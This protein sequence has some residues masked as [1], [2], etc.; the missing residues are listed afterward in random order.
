MTQRC[1]ESIGI[2]LFSSPGGMR[3]T[4]KA[5]SKRPFGD[6]DNFVSRRFNSYEIVWKEPGS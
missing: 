6:N 1:W 3:T 2:D 4:E 5:C